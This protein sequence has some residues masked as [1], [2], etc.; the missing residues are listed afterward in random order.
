MISSGS[1][2]ID[3]MVAMDAIM[4]DLVRGMLFVDYLFKEDVLSK[5]PKYLFLR[6]LGRLVG[7]KLAGSYAK[8]G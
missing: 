4:I 6:Y 1:L 7:A 5:V 2:S 3:M 8:N